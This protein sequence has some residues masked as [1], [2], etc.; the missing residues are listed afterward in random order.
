MEVTD[1]EGFC[2]RN[3]LED[4]LAVQNEEEIAL[5]YPSG[6]FSLGALIYDEAGNLLYGSGKDISQ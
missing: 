1:H 6:P 4:Y 3:M 5:D 2:Y